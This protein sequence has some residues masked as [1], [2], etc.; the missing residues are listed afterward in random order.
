MYSLALAVPIETVAERAGMA[1]SDVDRVAAELSGED[2]VE[3]SE[4]ELDWTEFH[5]GAVSFR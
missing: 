3:L 1:A 5:Y 4:T 2:I